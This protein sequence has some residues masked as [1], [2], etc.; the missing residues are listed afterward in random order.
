MVR[1]YPEMSRQF[2]IVPPRR[3]RAFSFRRLTK[4]VRLLSIKSFSPAP[5]LHILAKQRRYAW[6]HA[7]LDVVTRQTRAGVLSYVNV[8]V[9]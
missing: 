9:I 7:A 6:T 2:R 1:M 8:Q 4:S 5:D 3:R